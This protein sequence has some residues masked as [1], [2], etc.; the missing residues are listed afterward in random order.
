MDSSRK[1]EMREGSATDG[2]LHDGSCR[3][4]KGYR[5]LTNIS[6]KASRRICTQEQMSRLAFTTIAFAAL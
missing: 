4:S 5:L 2:L 6:W 3:S 1:G